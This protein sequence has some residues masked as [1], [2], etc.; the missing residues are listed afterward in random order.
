[1]FGM[2]AAG[3]GQ[4]RLERCVDKIRLVGMPCFWCLSRLGPGEKKLRGIDRR[5]FKLRSPA[6][7]ASP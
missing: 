5:A 3:G 7:R 4:D 2:L 1:M 6:S